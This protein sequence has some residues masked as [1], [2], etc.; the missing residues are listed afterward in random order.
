MGRDS[1]EGQ[2]S[3]DPAALIPRSW[4]G[5]WG[6]LGQERRRKDGVL[7][8]TFVCEA[9]QTACDQC[10]RPLGTVLH[11][12]EQLWRVHAH[13]PDLQAKERGDAERCERMGAQGESLGSCQR[14]GSWQDAG[15][16]EEELAREGGSQIF[17]SLDENQ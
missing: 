12:Q 14:P 13:P 4:E 17:S 7:G 6:G 11:Q 16:L 9:V 1:Q 3:R 10:L 8:G 2:A 5:K 15:T